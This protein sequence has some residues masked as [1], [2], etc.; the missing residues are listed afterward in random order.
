MRL[1]YTYSTGHTA[2]QGLGLSAPVLYCSQASLGRE[3][4]F[5]SAR[6]W[7][8]GI[9]H[10]ANLHSIRALSMT[11]L[12]TGGWSVFITRC[13]TFGFPR[14]TQRRRGFAFSARRS[15]SWGLPG[16]RNQ[17]P[18]APP[19]PALPMPNIRLGSIQ[20]GQCRGERVSSSS[21]QEAISLHLSHL[22]GSLSRSE[23]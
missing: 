15:L 12:H 2:L 19:T 23:H 17:R 3:P 6:L 20:E 7:A 16:D 5:I 18:T 11:A 9:P 1:L 13:V 21:L 14:I 10:T 4:V 22:N 8:T